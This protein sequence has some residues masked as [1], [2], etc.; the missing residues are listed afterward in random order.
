MTAVPPSVSVTPRRRGR[1]IGT[2]AVVALLLAASGALRLGN[3]IG[4]ALARSTEAPPAGGPLI[5]PEP[6]EALAAALSAREARLGLR[7]DALADQIAALALTE[8]A[9]NT[10]IA[11][12]VAAEQ[13]LAATLAIADG[14]AEADI[15][16]LTTVYEAMKPKEASQLF[17]AMAPEFAAGFLGRMRPDAAAAVLAGME[18]DTAYIISVLLAGRNAAAPL[19]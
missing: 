7:E 2:L 5:C 15:G 11:A 17:S 10:R 9:V 1:A 13:A 14:A 16:R 6:P 19:E 4:E 3:G 18:P 8:A 12:L